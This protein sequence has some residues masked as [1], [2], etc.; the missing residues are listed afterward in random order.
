MCAHAWFDATR[1]FCF[2]TRGTHACDTRVPFKL[3][4]ICTVLQCHL[5]YMYNKICYLYC[6][7]LKYIS[8]HHRKVYKYRAGGSALQLVRPNLIL[9][10]IQL[11]AWAADNF[12][13]SLILFLLVIVYCCKCNRSKNHTAMVFIT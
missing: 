8:H 10:T 9:S 7:E 5:N 4:V 6:K 13:T 2:C 12:T 1:V 11:N 3:W